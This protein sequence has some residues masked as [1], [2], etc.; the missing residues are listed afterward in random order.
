M[1][2]EIE[3]NANFV[4]EVLVFERKL[5]VVKID[6]Q[7]EFGDYMTDRVVTLPAKL[8]T[9]DEVVVMVRFA[10]ESGGNRIYSPYSNET[11]IKKR[12]NTVKYDPEH[13]PI[14]ISPD[15]KNYLFPNEHGLIEPER[16]IIRGEVALAFYSL[17]SQTA[18]SEY[19][20][21]KHSF[22]DEIPYRLNDQIATMSNMGVIK[23]YSDNTFRMNNPITR[24]EFVT[25]AMKFYDAEISGNAKFV[26]VKSDFWAKPY[27]ERAV[28]IGI[29][30]GYKD[31]SF[32]P[33]NPITRAEV[34]KVI[35]RITGRVGLEYKR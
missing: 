15:A 26:D 28:A 33:D 7:L 31:G 13:K 9:N 8:G 3:Y 18:K 21:K 11:I 23:G 30:N 17:L 5:N 6:Y 10:S 25:I 12:L 32:K 19:F 20:S 35:N 22:K 27:I 14:H 4:T 2:D 24:A 16:P 1:Y 34:A 29:I